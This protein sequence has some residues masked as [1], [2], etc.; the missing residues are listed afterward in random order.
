M[1][2]Y[3]KRKIRA[4][5][6]NNNQEEKLTKVVLNWYPGHM[7]KTKRE[8]GNIMSMV[9]I[10]IEVIDSRVPFSSRIP[11]LKKITR[12]KQHMTPFI[13]KDHFEFVLNDLLI[14]VGLKLEDVVQIF[15][16]PEYSNNKLMIEKSNDM[17]IPLHSLA[18][19]FSAIIDTKYQLHYYFST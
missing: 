4:E 2:M 10:V 8:I 18:H 9:D 16:M 11:D 17:N 1:D 5:K 14:Q 15:G 13:S 3:Q 12:E 19:V 7:A 6:K